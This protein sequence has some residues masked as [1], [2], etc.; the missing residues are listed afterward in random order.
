MVGVH[1]SVVAADACGLVEVSLLS[2]ISS[3]P[4]DIHGSRDGNTRNDVQGADLGVADFDFAVRAE[5]DSAGEGRVY[6]VRYVV[7]DMAGNTAV[8]SSLVL[9]P[10]NQEG[11]AEAFKAFRKA[12]AA[13]TKFR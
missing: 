5:R 7:T 11:A 4:D 3:E 8:G 2:V 10:R 6:E 13:G 12:R 9:V 1:A